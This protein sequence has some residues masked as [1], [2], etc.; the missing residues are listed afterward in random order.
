MHRQ[1]SVID[2]MT[3]DIVPLAPDDEPAGFDVALRGYDRSQVNDYLE[4]VEVALNE[5]D[6]RHAQDIARVGS[7][8]QELAAVRQ[9]LAEAERNAS[10]EAPTPT[11]VGERVATLLRLADEEAA[12]VRAG[13]QGEADSLL[14]Q[15]RRIIERESSERKAALDRRDRETAGTAQSAENQRQQAQRD[16]EVV[17]GRAERDAAGAV[18]AAKRQGET[19]VLGARKEAQATADQA[20]AVAQQVHQQAQD[21]AATMTREARRQ[22]EELS[23]QRDAI[24][25][26]LQQLRD[27]L[28]GVMGSVSSQ[29]DPSPAQG[30][31]VGAS[32]GPPAPSSG[33]VQVATEPRRAG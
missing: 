10:G 2:R 12:A 33:S 5:A 17:R 4:R 15:A 29:A 19:M 28:A 30:Q 1:L 22:V 20:R 13:A 6:Q 7:V 23:R 25:R 18:D 26:Q 14:E 16:A 3:G 8:E 11:M 24:A 32:A 31:P 9:Q 27:T 21:E